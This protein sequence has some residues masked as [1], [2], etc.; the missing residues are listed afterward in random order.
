M[1]S[2]K[3]SLYARGVNRISASFIGLRTMAQIMG[4]CDA[5]SVRA[6][7]ATLRSSYGEMRLKIVRSSDDRSR[8][9][10][11]SLAGVRSGAGPAPGAR[12]FRRGAEG[13]AGGADRGSRKGSKR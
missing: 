13:E 5:Q 2:R 9:R 8:A 6:I 10:K 11:G 12:R 4:R 1:A 7:T 3:A